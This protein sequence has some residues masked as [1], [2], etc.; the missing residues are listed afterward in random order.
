MQNGNAARRQRVRM[1]TAVLSA[2]VLMCMS[3]GTWQARADQDFESARHRMVEQQV[4]AR[5][6]KNRQVL[7]AMR[8]VPRHRMIPEAY[9]MD[10]YGDHPVP[11]GY[12]QTISQPFI[13]GYMTEQLR[14][15]PGDKVLEI[16]T[17]SGYQ[18]AVLGQIT[19]NVY[20][21][22]I[23]PDLAA[24]AVRTL[25]ELGYGQINVRQGDGYAGWPEEGPW[26]AIVVTAAAEH[27]PPPLVQQLKP[28]GVMC[29]PVGSQFGVQ[30][31]LLVEK[32]RQG[33]VSTR[34]LM[35]VRFVPLTRQAK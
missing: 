25:T 5:G 31:L 2:C 30:Y 20:T 7:R 9:R 6:V 35:P 10:P 12:G 26:D 18:A 32:N 4:A 11:I 27:V 21:I 1:H 17:G 22:E 24:L 3:S 34:N 14:L 29:I 15:E 33:R 28:G 23:I 19:T 8:T 16:G 13:V